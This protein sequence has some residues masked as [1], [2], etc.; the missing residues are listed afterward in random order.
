LVVASSDSG[1]SEKQLAQKDQ[2]VKRESS[3]RETVRINVAEQ[4]DLDKI[5]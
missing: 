5:A 1:G 2:A 4:T 3:I